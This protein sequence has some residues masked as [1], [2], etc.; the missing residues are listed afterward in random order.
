[1]SHPQNSSQRSTLPNKPPQPGLEPNK[2]S[3][4]QT[5]GDS[6]SLLAA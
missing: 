4:H 3:L 2:Q 1:M 6:V 5:Q